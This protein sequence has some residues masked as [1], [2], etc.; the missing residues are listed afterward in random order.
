MRHPEHVVT[1]VSLTN[2]DY[3]KTA[4]G[5]NKATTARVIDVTR[6]E[7]LASDLKRCSYYETCAAY[8]KNVDHVF[9]DA[10][11]KIIQS[12]VSTTSS[13]IIPT[14]M[15]PVIVSSSST[16]GGTGT[17]PSTPGSMMTGSGKGQPPPPPPN[18]P[19]FIH[20]NHRN[21]FNPVNIE[22]PF[23]SKVTINNSTF[24]NST[25]VPSTSSS[26][27][28]AD[29]NNSNSS[30]NNNNNNNQPT[31]TRVVS[32]NSTGTNTTPTHVNYGPAKVE[33]RQHQQ[34]VTTDGSC[35]SSSGSSTV[36]SFKSTADTVC[37]DPTPCSTPNTT[38]KSKRRSNIFPHLTSSK[39]KDHSDHKKNGSGGGGSSSSD[40]LGSG[41]AIP[42]HQGYL[43]KK[44]LKSLN[45][46]W[47]KKYV[48]LTND[49][50]LSYHP[51][52]HD[53]M[54]DVNR[55][56]IPLRHT[57]VKIR[58]GKKSYALSKTV[59]NH[60]LEVSLKSMTLGS[61]EKN[62]PIPVT[63]PNFLKG[64]SSSAKDSVKR[65]HHHRRAKSN[66]GNLTEDSDGSEFTIVSLENKEWRFEADNSG[67]R[68]VWVEAIEQQILSSLQG[69]ESDKS[70]INGSSSADQK[71]T[72]QAIRSVAGND[73]CADCDTKS[74]F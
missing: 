29:T 9:I 31:G 43:Y 48:T 34:N 50:T 26:A 69:L 8:G 70:K 7:K 65:R 2:H 18:K 60:D 55:K 73:R 4:G 56:D 33:L 30:N 6:A 37:K 24:R 59:Q 23:L 38:R 11:R 57:T 39:N 20:S 44:S 74:E 13:H 28:T 40:V 15:T 53:Y 17:R 46:D 61:S 64:L 21:S 62:K 51:T 41:R 22:S 42:I 68:D 14:S 71:A 3:L 66:L 32:T 63:N 52:L 67:D 47:K 1:I 54:N 72:I 25:C 12:R 49:G 5:D 36:T 19:S 16:S 58:S 10:C 45:K 35:L 27:S